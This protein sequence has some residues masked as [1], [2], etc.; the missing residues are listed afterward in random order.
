ML[1][2]RGAVWRRI[3]SARCSAR[4]VADDATFAAA[5]RDDLEAF[6][7]ALTDLLHRHEPRDGSGWCPVCEVGG[8]RRV[9]PCPVWTTVLDTF[10]EQP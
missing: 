8:V 2:R 9:W 1:A 6:G 5:G 4:S 10:G 3:E 7:R